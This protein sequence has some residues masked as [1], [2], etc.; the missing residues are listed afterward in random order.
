VGLESVEFIIRIEE[1]FDVRLED[2]ET[3]R[4]QT[5]ADLERLVRRKLEA[6]SRGSA[7]V[8]AAISRVLVEEF[9]VAAA[10]VKPEARLVQDLGLE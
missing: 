1:T 5:V 9:G 2:D 7:G 10:R 6:E 3:L 8:F 4:V